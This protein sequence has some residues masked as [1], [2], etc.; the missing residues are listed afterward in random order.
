MT[1]PIEVDDQGNVISGHHR[2]RIVKD[3]FDDNQ[4]KLP[5]EKRFY[6]NVCCYEKDDGFKCTLEK[7]HDGNHCAHG[8]LGTI[9]HEWPK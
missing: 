8:T 2:V 9:V 5:T 1:T 7:G 6:V 4:S 3:V